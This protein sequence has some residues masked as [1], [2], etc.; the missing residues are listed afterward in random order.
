MYLKVI[1]TN[2]NIAQSEVARVEVASVPVGGYSVSLTRPVKTMWLVSYAM[3]MAIFGAVI[4]LI[5]RKR[6]R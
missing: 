3:L 4:S 5:G 1:D 6:K 2:D